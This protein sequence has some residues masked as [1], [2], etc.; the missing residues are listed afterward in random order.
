LL[1]DPDSNMPLNPRRPCSKLTSMSSLLWWD[2]K[3]V[4]TLLFFD[5]LVLDLCSGCTLPIWWLRF[6][7]PYDSGN[8]RAPTACCHFC[9]AAQN[10]QT[11][12]KTSQIITIKLWINQLIKYINK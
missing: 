9:P 12:I 10:W 8:R 5:E 2:W 3:L 11:Y 4:E 7:N 6:A 1:N